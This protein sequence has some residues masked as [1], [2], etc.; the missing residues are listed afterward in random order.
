M[1][2]KLVING[3][4]RHF[5]GNSYVVEDE[6]IDSETNEK[7]VIYR[8][9]YGDR[10]LYARPLSMF[11]SPVDTEKYPDVKQKWRFELVEGVE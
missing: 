8:A 4:Y 6:A 2:R 9:L 11:L 7:L 1:D 10:A 5:K 3:T